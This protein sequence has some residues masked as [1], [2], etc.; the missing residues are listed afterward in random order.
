MTNLTPKMTEKEKKAKSAELSDDMLGN[1]AGGIETLRRGNSSGTKP[2]NND[3]NELS[4]E[5][6]DN[7]SGGG[8]VLKPITTNTDGEEL[9]DDEL[10]NVTGG[11]GISHVVPALMQCPNCGMLYPM[12]GLCPNCTAISKHEAQE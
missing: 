6:L 12:D 8:A 10:G 9:M 3:T 2:S 4:D 1:V 11:E 7:V 5:M